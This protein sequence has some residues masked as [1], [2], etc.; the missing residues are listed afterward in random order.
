MDRLEFK[1][2]LYLIAGLACIVLSGVSMF[3]GQSKPF[4][5]L[6]GSGLL[7]WIGTGMAWQ[8]KTGVSLYSLEA[9]PINE[10]AVESRI[11]EDAMT[12]ELPEARQKDPSCPRRERL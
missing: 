4:I 11:Q 1:L 8:K 6:W 2:G 9:A 12:R 10:D 7:I 5:V 3:L